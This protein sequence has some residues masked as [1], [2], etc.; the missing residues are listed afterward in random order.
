MK[1]ATLNDVMQEISTSPLKRDSFLEK[2]SVGMEISLEDE[3][4]LVR[5]VKEKKSINILDVKEEPLSDAV[6]IQQLGTQAYAIVPLISR[7]K[8][9]GLI[10]V[11]NYFNRKQIVEEDMQFLASF[12]NHIASAIESAR[13]FEQVT[14]AEQQLE[15]IFE[16]ISDMVYFVNKDYE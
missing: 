16:S 11:D 8:V 6:L 12:S 1:H 4:A 3:G 13:L 7:N 9:I 10:W 2:L 15:N 5:A 14:M